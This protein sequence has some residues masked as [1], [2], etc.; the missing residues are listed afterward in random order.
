[1]TRPLAIAL[2]SHVASPSA[3]TGAE[4]SLALLAEGLAQRGHRTSVIAPGPWRLA[5]ALRD[6][7]VEVIEAPAPACWLSW[8]APRSPFYAAAQWARFAVRA[9]AGRRRIA[10]ALARCAPDVVHVNCLPH[11]AG[12]AAAAELGLPL[13]WHVREILPPGPRRR[14]FARR[15]AAAHTIV[16]VSEAAAA[17]VREERPAAGVEVV[18]N[19]VRPAAAVGA[20]EA[21]RRLGLPLDGCLV[22]LF[23]QLLPHKGALAFLGAA[24]QALAEAPALRFVLAGPGPSSF[25]AE[26]RRR[27]ERP[28]LRGRVSILPAQPD[29]D[30]LVAAADVV[31][32]ATLTPDPAP[33]A[34]LEAMSAGRAVV[35]FDSG[36][37]G[38]MLVDGV[39]GALCP[40][41]DEA[42][43]ARA[44]ARL[45][46]DPAL[47]AAMGE[48]GRRRAA[49]RFS[50]DGH[51]EKMER[52]LARAAGTRD[53][54]R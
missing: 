41:G 3:P 14:W 18:Y 13:V 43:L 34:V 8:W 17:W 19:G 7:G 28:P 48:A 49:E 51:V 45:G 4:R 50:L 9:P 12:A 11:L 21:R 37:A 16:A 54:Y 6:C 30:A 35:A 27:A 23:G 20:D 47:R 44:F 24:E 33:R 32:L 39:T 26:L 38:E 5:Q 40:V 52:L 1:V 2:L 22:G 46:R 10:R 36:G 31:A 29:S 25:V 15:L 42:A 53:S